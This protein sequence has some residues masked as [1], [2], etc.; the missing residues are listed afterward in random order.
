[1]GRTPDLDAVET[2]E[3][4]DSLKAVLQH[5]GAERA[6]FLLERLTA[7]ARGAGVT[8]ATG[9][10]TPYV[11]TIPPERE[12]RAELGPRHRTSHS[13]DHPLECGRH[14]PAG[15]QGVLRARRPHRQLPVGGDALRHRLRTFLARAV[16]AAWRRS[17][18]YAGTLGARHLCAC[19]P[20][21]TA[22]RRAI[23]CAPAG[24]GGRRPVVLSASLA[25]AGLLAIPHGV[26]GAWAVDGDLPGAVPEISA[27]AWHCRY[28]RAQSVGLHGRRRDGRAG[29]ARRHIAW[30]PRAARQ[31]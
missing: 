11:N 10:N 20:R 21:G 30:R 8:T 13:L 9:V 22:E 16:G 12:E 24:S 7:E 19:L 26:D 25:D 15:Q 28:R 31:S 27:W 23:A 5:Q 18:L 6:S 1:M 29:I 3:W 4:V 14:H 17:H 2:S